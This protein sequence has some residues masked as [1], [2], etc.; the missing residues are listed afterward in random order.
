MAIFVLESYE[1]NR[2]FMKLITEQECTSVYEMAL[3]NRLKNYKHISHFSA[4]ELGR[5]IRLF[6]GPYLA[7]PWSA[8]CY[9][10]NP[11]LIVVFAVILAETVIRAAYNSNEYTWYSFGEDAHGPHILDDYF[12]PGQDANLAPLHFDGYEA[13]VTDC[14]SMSHND[15]GNEKDD[16]SQE[17]I[18]DI[19]KATWR[20]NYS[21]GDVNLSLSLPVNFLVMV[22]LYAQDSYKLIAQT[23]KFLYSVTRS[24]HYKNMKSIA[25]Y[26][27]GARAMMWFGTFFAGCADVGAKVAFQMTLLTKGKN[28]F[29]IEELLK[30]KWQNLPM[31]CAIIVSDEKYAGVIPPE[32]E[33]SLVGR[34]SVDPK[35]LHALVIQC[36]E[37]QLPILLGTPPYTVDNKITVLVKLLAER[38]DLQEVK[39]SIAESIDPCL[40]SIIADVRF[41]SA[42]IHE[43]ARWYNKNQRHQ[44]ATLRQFMICFYFLGISEELRTANLFAG[45]L[46]RDHFEVLLGS[47]DYSCLFNKDFC[48]RHQFSADDCANLLSMVAIREL[49][50]QVDF[51]TEWAKRVMQLFDAKF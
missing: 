6:L 42:P 46:D 26:E 30:R 10:S 20:F 15:T 36:T 12:H 33:S 7:T 24:H 50:E 32:L 31:L 2:N 49:V 13:Q 41:A 16:S 44:E 35:I 27:S 22:V 17:K 34:I 14:E 3:K 51:R 39:N 40:Y 21:D 38:D 4:P 45:R 25:L 29:W 23:C 18:I 1:L 11:M 43:I 37:Q 19:M 8:N 47:A 28:Y 9:F 5:A 48:K